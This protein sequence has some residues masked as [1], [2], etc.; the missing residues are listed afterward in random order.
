MS[1]L[2]PFFTDY[3]ALVAQH[4]QRIVPDRGSLVERAMAYTALAPSKQVRAVLVM[5]CAELCRGQASRAV[6]AAAAI[7]LVHAASLILDDLP[8]MDDA[9]L[10]RGRPANHRQ[11]GE[12]T[13]ILAAF[14]LL[15]LAYG[16]IG[17]GYEPALASRMREL[18]QEE[19]TELTQRRDTLLA[20]MKVL[21]VPKDPNDAKNIILEIRG[22]TGGDEAALFASDLFRMYS[23]YAER[24]GWKVEVLSLSE[25]GVGGTKEVIAIISGKNVYSR[26]KYESGVHRVQRV[27]ATEA[28]GRIHTST[29]T[30]AIM[31]IITCCRVAC[32]GT[33]G[34]SREGPAERLHPLNAC[35]TRA[36]AR[37]ARTSPTM[38][39]DR[40]AGAKRDA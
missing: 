28:S 27:P 5:L 8:S 6:P 11:F 3:Q 17:R 7:E 18:A 4:L 10:R 14:G 9:P 31:S 23:R 33:G 25:S 16:E 30:V 34:T 39:T 35:A 2:P 26:L 29:A 15:N 40:V 13:A 1:A 38:A 12:A 37:S 32:G 24:N 21:L 36:A 20:E 22:G 19:M